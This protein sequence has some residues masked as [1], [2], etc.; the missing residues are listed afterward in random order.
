MKISFR[1]Y[2]LVSLLAALFPISVPAADLPVLPSSKN[3]SSG[4]LANGVNYYIVSN[5]SYKGMADIALVQ[6]TGYADES[7]GDRGTVNVNMRGSL[8]EL[9]H[10]PDH[11]PFGYLKGKAVLPS[12][13][14]FARARADASV[15]RFENLIQARKADIIDS[16]L[17]L[18]FDIIGRDGGKM[19]ASYA[20]ER[21]AVIISGDVSE[22]EIRGK[23]DML[24]MFIAKRQGIRR[25]D[26]YE[27]QE[28]SSSQV[29]LEPQQGTCSVS[30]V[31]R[32]PRTPRQDMQTVLPLVTSRY[33]SQLE[34][35]VRKRLSRALRSESIPYSS[36]DFSYQGSSDREGDELFRIGI[37]TA[38]EYTGIAMRILARTLADI[39]AHGASAEEFR[40]IENETNIVLRNRYGS[41]VVENARYVDK[42][43]SAFLYG[44][45]LASDS[46]NLR[47]FSNRSMD[48][49]TSAKLF[50]D[51][52][53]ELL[54]RSRNLTI[55][56]SESE[57]SKSEDEIRNAFESA[58]KAPFNS[59]SRSF[60]ADTLTLRKASGKAK[61]RMVSP[62]PLYGGEM[63]TFTNGMKVIFKQVK[64]DGCIHYTW[65]VKNGFSSMQGLKAGESAYL[66]DMFGTYRVAGMP[67]EDFMEML[68]SNGVT[69][70]ISTSFS[71]F[72][73]S[74]TA[75]SSKIQLLMKALLSMAESRGTDA[76]AYGYYRNCE[77]LRNAAPTVEARLD[78]IMN[79]E[80]LMSEYK[81][82]GRLADD[83][84][85]RAARYFDD[86]FGRS[87]DG[88]LII[89]GDIDGNLLRKEMLQYIGS[90]KT[91]KVSAYRSRFKKGTITSRSTGYGL[92]KT[93]AV[94][95]A[96]SAPINY[97][98]ENYMAASI[99]ASAM[100]EAVGMAVSQAGW[101]MK[102][103][104]EIRMFPDER[105]TLEMVLTPAA[106]S[107]LPASLM[108]ED[109]ADEV[110]AMAREAISRIGSS[111]ISAD[112]LKVGKAV[113]QSTCGTWTEDPATMT[114]MLALRYS[115]GKDLITDYKSRITGVSAASVNPI[116]SA[117]A[118]DGIAEFVIRKENMKDYVEVPVRESSRLHVEPMVPVPGS[119]YYPYDGSTVPADTTFDIHVFEALITPPEAA[120]STMVAAPAEME[121][122]GEGTEAGEAGET[123]RAG[124]IEET[125]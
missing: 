62:E 119:L 26:D 84:Q 59:G 72:R 5:P 74:G 69:M 64:G 113:L 57:T 123:G 67:G 42:C 28:S 13:F 63:W 87:N 102:A 85:A 80:I 104:D 73:A 32:Y 46:D 43:I 23:M 7:A 8:T 125:E 3:I 117:L 11:S 124:E 19:G 50:N 36:I 68:R 75:A 56:C 95:I 39:D 22:A 24:S 66:G 114:D 93:P 79:R 83:F 105:L 103:S 60:M 122:A 35:L 41:S 92:G 77:Q 18:V 109:S 10:F 52:V 100:K 86:T 108:V 99:A 106:S 115:Y 54:D 2:F 81:R 21:Q 6:K 121:I 76:S 51:F 94:G 40:D 14:G 44:S 71:E 15:Y 30:A 58:W 82:P 49:A 4:K 9:Q 25:G 17:L 31:Y 90:F 116:L 91:E 101:T 111:G 27:W 37:S 88:A 47:F 38:G 118:G 65:L 45:S 61:L 78:S 112:A 55:I 107:G 53:S 70:D 12:P 98:A 34:I 96:M 120:D 1:K 110:L 97:T 16:T 89:V 33:A 29:V 48:A 20:P